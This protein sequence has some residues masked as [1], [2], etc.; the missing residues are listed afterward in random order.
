MLVN[1]LGN[2]IEI[3]RNGRYKLNHDYAVCCY[4]AARR[5]YVRTED[6]CGLPW[7][8]MSSFIIY[9]LNQTRHGVKT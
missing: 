4:F 6:F 9:N 1:L 3:L 7:Y 8:I 5:P 2:I